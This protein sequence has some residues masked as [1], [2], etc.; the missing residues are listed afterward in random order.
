MTANNINKMSSTTPPHSLFC[1]NS[2]FV[3]DFG[4]LHSLIIDSLNISLDLIH[5]CK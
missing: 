2:G 5:C 1:L 4:T 3:H